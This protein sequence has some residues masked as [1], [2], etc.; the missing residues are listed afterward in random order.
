VTA[1]GGNEVKARFVRFGEIELDG[2]RYER[3]VVVEGGRISRRHKRA[4]RPFRDRFGHTPLSL[5]EPIPWQCRRLIVGTGAE[6]SLPIMDEVRERAR[7][8]GIE[9][10]AVPTEEACRL[11]ARSDPVETAAILHVTC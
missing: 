6:G 7:T 4:S 2:H 8:L 11:L 10:I 5:E 3:D 1:E 9:L